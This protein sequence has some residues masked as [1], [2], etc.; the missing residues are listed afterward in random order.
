MPRFQENIYDMIR[1]PVR[2]AGIKTKIGC[3]GTRDTGISVSQNGG[4]LEIAQTWLGTILNA[5]QLNYKN[6]P[7][8]ARAYRYQ[9]RYP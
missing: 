6:Q 8:A 7:R 5:K 3:H 4:N 2:A 1:R 9:K